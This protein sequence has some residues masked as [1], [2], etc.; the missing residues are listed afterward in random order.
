[1]LALVMAMQ[2]YSLQVEM[3]AVDED[4]LLVIQEAERQSADQAHV[5]DLFSITKKKKKNPDCPD[6]LYWVDDCL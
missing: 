1:M 4:N 2:P 6:Y 3:L 5:S